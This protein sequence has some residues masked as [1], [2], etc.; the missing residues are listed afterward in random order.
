MQLARKMTSTKRGTLLLAGGAALL[1]GALILIYLNGYRNSVRSEGAPVT[2]LIASEN[3]PKGTSGTI[4]GQ[5]HLFRTTTMRESQLREGAFSDPANLNGQVVTQEIY[6]GSQLTATSFARGGKSLASNL[7]GT[8]RIVAVPLDSA[9]GLIGDI[10]EGSRVDIFAGFNVV[11]L[12]ADGT[13]VTGG[14]ARA[15]LK[16]IITNVPVVEIAGKTG[17]LGSN[18]TKVLI[19]LTDK[20]AADLAF[21]SDNGKVWL[22]MRPGAGAESTPPNLVTV[23]TVLLGATPLGVLRSFRGGR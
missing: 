22:V 14:Q 9:H 18:T 1:A 3:I 4:I 2:V 19:R 16:R 10:E 15:V 7:S 17:G 20:Q 8:D 23:E 6:K 13:P 11:P 12:R 21:S 5:K